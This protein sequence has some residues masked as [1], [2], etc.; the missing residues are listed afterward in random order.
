MT[1]EQH[2]RE[3]LGQCLGHPSQRWISYLTCVNVVYKA[4]E[5]VRA[6]PSRFFFFFSLFLN[7]AGHQ[8]TRTDNFLHRILM[9]A[10][11]AGSVV[12]RW[13]YR[14]CAR[15]PLR[16]AFPSR[17]IFSHLVFLKKKI[18]KKRHFP[19]FDGRML[20]FRLKWRATRSLPMGCRTKPIWFRLDEKSFLSRLSLLFLYGSEKK[21]EH[22]RGPPKSPGNNPENKIELKY[23]FF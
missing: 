12:H 17:D 16:F 11:L 8:L 2:F 13:S 22:I 3:W 1:S 23:I 4:E 6:F 15:Q 9:I 19:V 20:F 10:P 7:P 18:K 14:H 5:C 21:H